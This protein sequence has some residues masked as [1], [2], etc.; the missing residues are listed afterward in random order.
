MMISDS[1]K[2]ELQSLFEAL[3]PLT[4]GHCMRTGIYMRMFCDCLM[5]SSP[6]LLDGDGNLKSSDVSLCA[7]E[8]GFYHH[9][10]DGGKNA[11]DLI[12]P[13]FAG[14]LNANG[15]YV[16]GLVDTV[17]THGEHWDGTGSRGL[18][19]IEI[20]FWGRTCAIAEEYDDL[21]SPPRAISKR[22]A[23]RQIEELA[24]KDYDPELAS[25]F[26]RCTELQR[27]LEP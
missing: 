10:A 8:F 25:A 27:S 2:K 14:A 6:E 7:F 22:K 23:M 26:V 3:P 15:L 4:K 16:K 19:G 24:G 5:T 17:E 20:P 18:C 11:K 13:I 21:T 1:Q 9:I 12:L